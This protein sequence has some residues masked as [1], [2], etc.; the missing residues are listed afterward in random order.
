M[1]IGHAPQIAQAYIRRRLFS[2]DSEFG[3]HKAVARC[4]SKVL[5]VFA[6]S[7]GG[8]VI[9]PHRVRRANR[10]ATG[11]HTAIRRAKQCYV[12]FTAATPFCSTLTVC[13]RDKTRLHKRHSRPR[14]ALRPRLRVN[15]VP[16]N[17]FQHWQCPPTKPSR[18]RADFLEGTS[19][20]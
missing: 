11:A 17:Y 18:R 8:L 7:K 10:A 9:R 14:T 12:R 3:R 19:P 15:E 5:P 1:R 2:R 6:G 4:D 13:P 20:F 16:A